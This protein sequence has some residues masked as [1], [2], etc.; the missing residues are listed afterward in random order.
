[1]NETVTQLFGMNE[2][3]VHVGVYR[4]EDFFGNI[5]FSKWNGEYWCSNSPHKY[6][7][8]LANLRSASCYGASI[9]GWRGLAHKPK[10]K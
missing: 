10:A 5:L 7:A 6:L 4:I 9:I 2:K 1:M 8:A 3:P